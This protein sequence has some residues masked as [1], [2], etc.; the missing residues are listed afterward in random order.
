M[1]MTAEDTREVL[2]YFVGV[3]FAG[4]LLVA[5]VIA[6]LFRAVRSK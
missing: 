1:G 6:L 5:L 3:G 2:L 4:L